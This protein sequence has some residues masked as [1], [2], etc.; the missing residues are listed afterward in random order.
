MNKTNEV[1]GYCLWCFEEYLRIF[2]KAFP[3]VSHFL[4]VFLCCFPSFC[5]LCFYLAEWSRCCIFGTQRWPKIYRFKLDSEARFANSFKMKFNAL[6]G[7]P[8][9]KL[10]SQP[11]V[12]FS[13]SVPGSHLRFLDLFFY[14][15]IPAAMVGAPTA[16]SW[17]PTAPHSQSAKTPVWVPRHPIALSIPCFR[18]DSGFCDSIETIF[19]K[20]KI[21]DQHA[22]LWSIF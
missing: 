21:I 19:S 6:Q 9:N 13:K 16:P 22:M 8:E 10:H 4:L 20:N 3:R 11:I 1:W 5:V 14:A 17:R 2:M 18:I 12:N 7:S 15:P